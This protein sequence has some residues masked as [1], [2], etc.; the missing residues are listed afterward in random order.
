MYLPTTQANTTDYPADSA[1]AEH[2]WHILA[3]FW[4]PLAFVSEIGAEPLAARLLDTDL[5]IYK[6]RQDITVAK[7]QCPHRGAKLSLGWL[8]DDRANVVCPFHGHHYDHLGACTRIPSYTNPNQLIP[9]QMRLTRYQTVQRYGLLWVCLKDKPLRPLPEWP[10]LENHDASWLRIEIPKG[11]WQT[12]AS[13]HCEN[14]NDIA[15]L[16]WV[17]MKT[18]GNR[19]R[20]QLDDYLLRRTDYGLHMELPYIEVERGFNDDNIGEREVYYSHDLTYPFAT[21][22]K[23]DYTEEMTSHFYDIAAPVSAVETAI[24]QISLTNI[25]GATTEDYAQYQLVT[26][27]ED[28]VVVESQR[29]YPVPLNPAA[30]VSIPADKFSIQY[31]RDLVQLFGLGGC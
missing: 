15:H 23:V 2:D 6:T 12:S 5:V 4:H 18:F 1:I 13:R 16:S 3:G 31:R 14:F 28:I 25:P 30:E 26:N 11:L 22:L 21:D 7:D 9:T 27:A 17:H 10:L 8:D 19:Q 20:P 24:Y 29:P